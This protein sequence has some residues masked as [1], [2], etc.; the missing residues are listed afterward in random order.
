M[1]FLLL[2]IPLLMLTLGFI[3]FC[4]LFNVRE[5]FI[6]TAQKVALV[7][8]QEKSSAL[9]AENGVER[10]RSHLRSLGYSETLAEAVRIDIRA[11]GVREKLSFEEIKISIPLKEALLFSSFTYPI[12]SRAF[13]GQDQ[14]FGIAFPYATAKS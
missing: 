3:E 13:Y 11:I 8:R 7:A 9:A 10:G 6:S 12:F 1:E 14:D 5:A 4:W 2:V